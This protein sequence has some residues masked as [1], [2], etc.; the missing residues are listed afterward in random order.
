MFGTPEL[1]IEA[2]AL[3]AVAMVTGVV[4]EVV[5]LAGGV[6]ALVKSAAQFGSPAR[7]DAPDG[8]V[9]D[10]GELATVSSGIGMPVL[11]QEF[12]EGEGHRLMR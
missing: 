2:S 3:G 11:S 9:V 12:C 10:S 6:L 8:P 1:L 4:G 5:F 7:E